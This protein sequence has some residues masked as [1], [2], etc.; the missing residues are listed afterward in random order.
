MRWIAQVILFI[1]GIYTLSLF[2]QRSPD[3]RERSFKVIQDTT[4]VQNYIFSGSEGAIDPDEYMIGPGDIIFI[5]ISGLQENSFTIPVDHEAN[6]YIPKIGGLALRNRTL[7]EAREMIIKQINRFY[8]EVDVFITLAEFKKIK[9]SLIGDVVKA[10]NFVMPGNSRLLDLITLSKGLNESANYRKI[11]IINDTEKEYDLL[12][13]LRFGKKE[14][15]PQ[16]REGDVV[17]IDKADKLVSVSGLVKYPGSY[18]YL[19][20]E[21]AGDLIN[22]AGGFLSKARMDSIE[23]VSFDESGKNQF[24]RYYNF[25]SVIS[26]KVLLQNQDHV[27]I[28]QIPEYMV[29]RY[30]TLTGYIKYP[31]FYKIVKDKTTLTE[32]IK[33]AGGFSEEASLTEASMTR[34]VGSEVVDPEF[35]RLK[36]IP[37]SELTE[38][39]YDYLKARSRQRVG[40][41]V[42]D[43]L[44]LFENNNL[45][46]DITLIEGDVIDVPRK[47]DYVIML[48]QV[49]NPGNIIYK[50]EYTYEDYIEL[51]GGYGWRA[52]ENEVRI[53]KAK[54][55]EWI[56][57]DDVDLIEPGDAIWIPE[58]PPGPKFWD[59]FTTSL[60]IVG[61]VATVIA[62]VVA[63]IAVSR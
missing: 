21:S 58:D 56:Y 13:F 28:R 14:F 46:E 31:G 22:L 3:Y 12:S 55:G 50:P 9:V 18:E 4:N 30:V 17:S 62:A 7:A 35:E 16:L 29:D 5:S 45:K 32:I 8:K 57:A 54:T 10:G 25:D 15:N 23:V 2:P 39:E 42:I 63:V 41:V 40:R 38:D 61:Q 20:D 47:K 6:L 49:V 52:L 53:V 26:D 34:S 33:E 27:I 37:P 48:G 43:F 51:A 11:K 1:I 36:L 24:S 60:S 59:V 19:E 44:Q